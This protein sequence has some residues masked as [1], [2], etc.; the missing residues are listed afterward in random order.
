MAIFCNVA[1][2]VFFVLVLVALVTPHY[3]SEVGGAH[4]GVKEDKRV[5]TPCVADKGCIIGRCW[6]CPANKQCYIYKPTCDAKCF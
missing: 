3:C 4:M 2:F 1:R 5:K 6:C